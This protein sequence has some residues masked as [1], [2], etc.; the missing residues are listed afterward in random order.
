MKVPFSR[1]GKKAQTFMES[2]I[3]MIRAQ[4]RPSPFDHTDKIKIW[5][6]VRYP[7]YRRDFDIEL[8]KD[9]LEKAG[10]VPNDRQIRAYGDSEAE[11]EVGEPRIR[12]RL[13]AV[14]P[15]PWKSKA[16]GQ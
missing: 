10:V 9:A 13:T 5:C 8:I 7:D 15:L 16:K 14:G 1:K 12:I 11:D 4:G 6:T 2:A 3:T